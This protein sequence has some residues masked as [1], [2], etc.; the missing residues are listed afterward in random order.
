MN[1]TIA[2]DRAWVREAV[3]AH[4][5]ALTRYARSFTG[6][7]DSARDIVQETF[8]RLCREPREKIEDHLVP[9]LFRVC[10]SRA[11]DRKRKEKRMTT[12]EPDHLA[13]MP[14]E[15]STPARA[16]EQGEA[17]ALVLQHLEALPERQREL[18]RL[19]FQNGLSYK[20]IAAITDL[21][22]SNVGF[23]L[24]TAIKALRTHLARET[25]LPLPRHKLG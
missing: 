8:L 4:A 2:A 3:E 6:D 19:K 17:T 15:S 13:R 9:W 25:D 7:E 18:I 14:D 11:L 16:A 12:L 20:E 22:V 5:P 21:S 23:I 1:R 24:H 10:R